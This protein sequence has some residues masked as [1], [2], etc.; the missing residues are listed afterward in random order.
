MWEALNRF[1]LDVQRPGR[2][3]GA[4]AGA[5][6][7]TRFFRSIVDFSQLPQGVDRLDDAGEEGWYY[8][9]AGSSSS[10]RSGRPDVHSR[11]LVGGDDGVDCLRSPAPRTTFSRGR[12]CCA[13]RR[14]TSYHCIESRG[15]EPTAVIGCSSSA[16]PAALIGLGWAGRRGAAYITEQAATYNGSEPT[17]G[18]STESEARREVGRLHVGSSTSALTTCSTAVHVSLLD[19][20]R[21]CYRMATGSTTSSSPTARSTAQEAMA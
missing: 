2:R 16:R 21:S 7:T 4:A 8:L 1:H 18:A 19:L 11:L 17:P 5:E 6:S 15:I 9:E 20:Q 14:R 3:R 10:G 13:R 12:C